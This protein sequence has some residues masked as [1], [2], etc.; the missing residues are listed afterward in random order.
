MYVLSLELEM[1]LTPPAYTEKIGL[2]RD[3]SLRGNL[4][5][6]V[7]RPAKLIEGSHSHLDPGRR[8]CFYRCWTCH[9][10]LQDHGRSWKQDHAS[11]AQSWILY[12]GEHYVP[13]RNPF[14]S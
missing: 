11:L 1:R 14:C 3:W 7:H 6:L 2:Q 12:G 9:L 13:S 4:P 5:G 10:R 8:R